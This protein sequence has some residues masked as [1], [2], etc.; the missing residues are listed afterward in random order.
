[1]AKVKIYRDPNI[2]NATAHYNHGPIQ[3]KFDMNS[4]VLEVDEEHAVELVDDCKDLS[5]TKVKKV[6][7]VKKNQKG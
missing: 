2:L 6:E 4:T 5:L 7:T 3:Y 1:M